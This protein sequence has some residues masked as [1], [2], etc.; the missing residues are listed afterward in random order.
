MATSTPDLRKLDRTY[1]PYSFH[2]QQIRWSASRPDI[3]VGQWIDGSLGA[4]RKLF[5]LPKDHGAWFVVKAQYA[6]KP[7]IAPRMIAQMREAVAEGF[8]LCVQLSEYEHDNGLNGPRP[9]V[10]S[11]P[12]V[13]R[14]RQFAKR[15]ENLVDTKKVVLCYGNEWSYTGGSG[16]PTWLGEEE[17]WHEREAICAEIWQDMGFY[18]GV[19]SDPNNDMVSSS[20]DSRKAKLKSRGVNPAHVAVLHHSYGGPNAAV[21]LHAHYMA[22]RVEDEGFACSVWSEAALVVNGSVPPSELEVRWLARCA[23][24]ARINKTALCHFTVY[25]SHEDYAKAMR[26]IMETKQ[27]ALRSLEPKFP[28]ASSDSGALNAAGTRSGKI[29]AA[30]RDDTWKNTQVG[31][32][33]YARTLEVYGGK[34]QD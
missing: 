23:I 29:A 12:L 27:S 7:E 33:A 6:V 16:D 28:L 34:Y 24:E 11:V 21:P 19:G 15:V 25:R 1:W 20:L 8:L 22:K 4:L 32:E 26:I 3:E 17:E 30:V 31:K 13:R 2:G 9:D 14:A 10:D 18:V 5:G